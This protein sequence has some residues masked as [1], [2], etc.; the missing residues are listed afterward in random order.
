[1]AGLG[2]RSRWVV[3]AIMLGDGLALLRGWR[4]ACACWHAL[5]HRHTR[6]CIVTL[7]WMLHVSC[8]HAWL[9]ELWLHHGLLIPNIWI[10]SWNHMRLTIHVRLNETPRHVIVS[11]HHL[12]RLNHRHMWLVHHNRLLLIVDDHNRLLLYRDIAWCMILIVIVIL[13][14]A[15]LLS[16][17]SD[18]DY[19]N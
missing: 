9:C 12:R 3:S 11:R 2:L 10:P 19:R 15:P 6:L 18:D 5:T 17:L 7:H 8:R 1:M 16:V 14:S 4:H 13:S